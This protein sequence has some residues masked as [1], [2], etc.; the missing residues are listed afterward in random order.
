LK[1]LVEADMTAVVL[2]QLIEQLVDFGSRHAHVEVAQSV[3][4]FLAVQRSTS[5]VVDHTKRSVQ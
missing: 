1:E 4:Q 3:C 2:V 5:V